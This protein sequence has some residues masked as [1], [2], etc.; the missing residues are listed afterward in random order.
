M[1]VIDINTIIVMN[2]Y[3]FINLVILFQYLYKNVVLHNFASSI[4]AAIIPMDMATLENNPTIPTILKKALQ[5]ASNN[6]D[7]INIVSNFI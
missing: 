1:L 3:V 4:E 6:A 5:L 2:K 7:I